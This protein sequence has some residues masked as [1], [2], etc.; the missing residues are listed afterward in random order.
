[1][2]EKTGFNGGIKEFIKKLRTDD[3]FYFKTEVFHLA[4][5]SYSSLFVFSVLLTSVCNC[6]YCRAVLHSYCL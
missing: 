3:R 6:M 1:V 2:I 5:L 4:A